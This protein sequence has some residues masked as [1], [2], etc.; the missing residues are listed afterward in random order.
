M[1]S[2]RS[3]H[4]SGLIYGA[5]AYALWGLFP[6]YFALLDAVPPVEVVAHRV[7]WSLLFMLIV[8]AIARTWRLLIAAFRSPRTLGLLALAS[9]FIAI[10]WGTY[11]YAVSSDQVVQAS[12]GYIMNPLVSV[13]LGVVILRERLRQLQW[14]AVGIAV[15]AVGI[16]TW[17]YGAPPWISLTLAISFALYG[18]M[19]KLAGVGS[20]QSLTVETTLLAPIAMA[21][22]IGFGVT[23]SDYALLTD[24]LT[25]LLLV[26]LGPITAIPLLAFGAAA[27]RIPIS[28]LGIM[29]YITPIMQFLIGVIIFSEPM[30][31]SRWIGFAVIWLAVVVFSLDMIRHSRRSGLDVIEPT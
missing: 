28:S 21:V 15:I 22:I 30:P 11:V 25:D 6:L 23:H 14:V 29:Q 2:Q 24:P 9:I 31:A 3:E 26:L 20:V 18:L 4:T 12:L 1:P 10:N 13:A 8:I 27:N 16:L 7:V 5:I 17:S 19:K